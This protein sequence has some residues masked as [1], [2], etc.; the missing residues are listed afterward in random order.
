MKANL[1]SYTLG[2]VLWLAC[3]F[4]FI[5]IFQEIVFT[6]TL[7]LNTQAYFILGISIFSCATLCDMLLASDSKYSLWNSTLFFIMTISIALILVSQ[8]ADSTKLSPAPVMTTLIIFIAC[9]SI[10]KFFS[11]DWR[12]PQFLSTKVMILGDERYIDTIK[13]LLDSS[14]GHFRLEG[15]VVVDPQARSRDAQQPEVETD[16]DHDRLYLEAQ[17]TGVHTIIVS[18]PERRGYMPVQQMLKCRM[19]G[20]NIVEAKTFYEFVSR[21]LYI[22][23]LKPSDIIFSSG[24]SLSLTRRALKRTGDFL[25]ASIG[26]LLCAPLFPLIALAIYFDSPGPIFFKQIRVGRG[27][28]LFHII[29]FRSMRADAEKHT[30]AVWASEADPRI[31]KIGSFLRKTRLDE[32]PQLI[33]VLQGDMSL[34]G[35]RPERP[36]FIGELKK[37]IPFYGERHSVKPGVTGWAQVRYP[38]G[39]SVEDA[40]EKLRYDLY[41]IKNQT[42]WLELEILLRTIVV[43]FSGHGAR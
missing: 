9:K 22:E 18:F 26:L 38:Y 20:M 29:K 30:G 27:D 6:D 7:S 1:L 11:S 36:E 13:D 35:P 28:K 3:A 19:L 16:I 39:A 41:Y 15:I 2:N 23:N 32:I 10:Y 5:A 37:S 40:L 33:N 12:Y 4:I 34:V 14:R 43:I 42:L 24:F 21:K 8:I 25:G 31:T 17:K